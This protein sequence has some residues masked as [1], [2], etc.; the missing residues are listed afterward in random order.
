MAERTSSSSAH[1]KLSHGGK[2]SKKQASAQK[3]TPNWLVMA[4]FMDIQGRL[5]GSLSDFL[6]K[7]TPEKQ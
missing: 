2:T 3:S 7:N 4:H 6:K 1:S 5:P